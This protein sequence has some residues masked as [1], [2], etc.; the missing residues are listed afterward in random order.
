[1]IA[2]EVGWGSDQSLQQF[3]NQSPWD[4]RPVRQGLATLM[5]MTLRPTAWVL[6][7]IAFAKHGRQ[8]AAIEAQFV[9]SQ[10]RVRNCQLGAVAMSPPG[11]STVRV[12]GHFPPPQPG[13][14]PHPRP[15]RAH[16]PAGQRHQ[17]FWRYY[18]EMLDDISG[19]WGI[20]LAPVV[21]DAR[22]YAS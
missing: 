8:S 18:V 4:P 6:E 7:D 13:A 5:A 1:R 17:P 22:H 14:P 9:P 12:H 15:P 20:P 16:A 19:D 10:G 11:R 3:I 21:V 2:D